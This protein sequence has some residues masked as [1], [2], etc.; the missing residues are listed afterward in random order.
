MVC[1]LC[2][3]WLART[4]HAAACAALCTASIECGAAE[5]DVPGEAT[6]EACDVFEKGR[7]SA[8]YAAVHLSVLMVLLLV[9]LV[10]LPR[11][12]LYCNCTSEHGVSGEA[13]A[14]A[15]DAFQKGQVVWH[16]AAAA[17]PTRPYRSL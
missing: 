4:D 3:G 6:A 14:E 10:V 13:I 2:R 11:Q 15:Y 9:L 16:V 7:W 1:C 12:M 17:V 5:H 8:A